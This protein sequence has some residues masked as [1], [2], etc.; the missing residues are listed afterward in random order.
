MNSRWCEA[1]GNAKSQAH[2]WGRTAAFLSRTKLIG[3]EEQRRAS[4][5]IL[6]FGLGIGL[7]KTALNH[8]EKEK[9]NKRHGRIVNEA[10]LKSNPASFGLGSSPFQMN[11]LFFDNFTHQFTLIGFCP[12]YLK[13]RSF[14]GDPPPLI[15]S[16]IHFVF[17]LFSD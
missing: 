1:K 2:A 7:I 15:E 13:L 16:Y 14:S 10:Y 5:N 9:T 12:F 11:F 17:S 4:E 8:F 6:Y 3:R